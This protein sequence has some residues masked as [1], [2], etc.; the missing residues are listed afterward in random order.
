MTPIRADLYLVVDERAMVD[1][2]FRMRGDR[3][4]QRI[5][6]ASWPQ[7]LSF[8]DPKPTVQI[9]VRAEDGDAR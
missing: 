4:A 2:L 1:V 5:A 6:V 9:H 7:V 3:A 8:L